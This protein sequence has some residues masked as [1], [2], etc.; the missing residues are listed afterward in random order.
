MH[1]KQ[2]KLAGFKSFVEPTVVYFSSQLVAILG[3]NGCGKSNIIDAVRWVMGESSARNLR[4][5]SM[6]DV[7]FNGSLKRKSLG[8]ASVELLF[9]NSLGR[10]AGPYGGY[11]DISVKRIVTRAGDS[12]Y[13][14]NGTRC[15]RRDVTELFLGT[16]AGS[17]GYSIIGQ[18]TISQ[19]I[20]AKPD[21]L[22]GFLE[23]AAGVSKYKE[24]RRETL[25]RIAQTRDNL[26]RLTDIREELEKQL[27]RLERQAKSAERYT[28]LKKQEKICKAEILALKWNDLIQ[29][30]R[31]KQQALAQLSLKYEQQQALVTSATL[32]VV[33]LNET[34]QSITDNAQQ[35]QNTFYQ[36]GTDIVRLEETI[37]Q[38][39]REKKR[40]EHDHK[41]LQNEWGLSNTQLIQ[42]QLALEHCLVHSQTSAQQL[43]SILLTLEQKQANWQQTDVLYKQLESD[44]QEFQVKANGNKEALQVTHV[45]LKHT[46]SRRQDILIRLE[47]SILTQASCDIAK[48]QTTQQNLVE[49]LKLTVDSEQTDEKHVMDQTQYVHQVRISLQNH[50]QQL[51]QLQDAFYQANS[52]YKALLAAQGAVKQSKPGYIKAWEEKLRLM[53][54]IQIDPLW[55]K[56][57]E[58]ILKDALL[59]YVLETMDE[60]WPQWQLCESQAQN[61]VTLRPAV[62]SMQDYPRLVDKIKPATPATLPYL[63]SIYTATDFEEART[64]LPTLLDHESIIT[65]TGIWIGKGWA[66]F[67]EVTEENELGILSRQQ[68]IKDLSK[69]VQDLQ[70]E[71]D[72]C[73]IARDQYQTQ[74]QTHESQL[75]L[76]QN[77]LKASSGESHFVKLELNKAKQALENAEHFIKQAAQDNHAL[78]LLLEETHSELHVLTESQTQ[79]SSQAEILGEQQQRFLDEKRTLS[80]SLTLEHTQLEDCR[81]AKHQAELEYDRA[82][83]KSQLL[84]EKIE[85]QTIQVQQLKLKSEALAVS[86]L[87]AQPDHDIQ[88][89]LTT[90]LGQHKALEIQVGLKQDELLQIRAKL[91]SLEKSKVA[92]MQEGASIQ[93][94]I[95]DIKIQEQT[96]LVRAQSIEE[97]LDEMALKAPELL[98][99]IPIEATQCNKEDTLIAITNKIINL[100]AINLAAIDEFDT[101]SQRIQYLD[102]QQSDLNQALATLEIAIEKMDKETHLRLE[103]TF[104]AVNTAFKSLFPRLFGGGRAQLELTCD[105]LLEAGIVV[106]AQP[107][108]KKNSS[109]HLLSGGEKAMTAVALIFAI[110]Q[111]NPSPFCMLDEVDAPLDDINVGRFCDLV[112]EMSQFVQFLF[113]THNKVTMELADDLIGVTMREPGVSRLVTVDVKQTVTM[114]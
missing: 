77:K 19:L 21:E 102:E 81:R 78:Q 111:L 3:P 11:A 22:R 4:G 12:T 16:G 54:M 76:A 104:E 106:M 107:P 1:L 84:Q 95:A 94:Q 64:W 57:C 86:L 62:E 26:N 39:E 29:Q 74:L 5:E 100:G 30:Q 68:K 51:H 80:Q 99:Q 41:Q 31:L 110:F 79:L 96:L 45:N 20:E 65:P 88:R 71:L 13:Y 114:E 109:I 28:D 7:I 108:G 46:Q 34:I 47:K 48:L 97:L 72:T 92:L 17:R 25:Q 18:G 60:L 23:E 73:R 98:R 15:R 103:T 87:A 36:M 61:I 27:Q 33:I 24:R 93:V 2:L 43:Q 53:E 70:H 101:E 9:D 112:K 49:K 35:I 14:L 32:E 82:L 63:E 37:R 90:L 58:Y 89:Q 55:L 113:I 91:D 59:S 56:A 85:R 44:W 50:Q 40:L 42:D 66:K 6:V 69:S 67:P 52:E 10:L 105:N 83:N 75:Q 38:L 8:Q